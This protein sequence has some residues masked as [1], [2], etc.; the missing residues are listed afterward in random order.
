MENDLIYRLALTGIPGIGHVHT[1]SLIDL[2]GEAR[3][4]FR[5]KATTLEKIDGIPTA[6]AAA[7][8]GFGDFSKQEKE[9]AFL[10]KHS[11]RPLFFTDHGYPRR[12]LDDPLSPPLL[13]YK[14]NADLNARRIVSIAGTRTHTDYGRDSTEQLIKGLAGL[15]ILIVSGLAYGIDTLAHQAALKN[16]LPTM[17]V[18]GHGLHTI[19]PPQNNALARQIVRSGGLLTQFSREMGPDAF[20]F[21]MR[22]RL[23]AAM[24]DATVIVESAGDGGS[25]ITAG[26]ANRCGKDLFAFPGRS[27]DTKSAGCNEL[28]RTGKAILLTHAKQLLNTMGWLEPAKNAKPVQQELFAPLSDHEKA[29]LQILHAKQP[30]PFDEIR[31]GCQLGYSAVNAAILNLELQGLIISLPG[32]SYKLA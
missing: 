14:G 15:D 10:E 17:A 30:M 29:I 13:F 23:I 9:I 31:G 2:F 16:T 3:A 27:T 11:I 1:K 6:C 28:I 4:V 7:I 5:A 25:L 21:P 24:S 26:E 12:L 8:A 19:Y 32:K 18:L 20:R 22:N